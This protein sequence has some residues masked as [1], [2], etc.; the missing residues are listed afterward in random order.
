M[1][2]KK[3]QSPAPQPLTV[4]RVVKGPGSYCGVRPGFRVQIPREWIGTEPTVDQCTVTIEEWERAEA[5]KKAAKP[6]APASKGGGLR[7]L[8]N[9]FMQS[10]AAQLKK[11]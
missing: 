10:A 6:A 3:T 5:A 7:E 11:A 4:E 9:S 2:P 1:P 8:A